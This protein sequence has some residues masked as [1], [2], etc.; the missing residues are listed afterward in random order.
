VTCSISS[1]TELRRTGTSEPFDGKV[2][3]CND[4]YGWYEFFYTHCLMYVVREEVYNNELVERMMTSRKVEVEVTCDNT[5]KPFLYIPHPTSS[6]IC[7]AGCR[8]GNMSF[9]GW[10]SHH[11]NR[12]KAE[13]NGRRR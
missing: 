9:V 3:H 4:Q 11:V 13:E 8:A 12:L 6:G 10:P 1:I 5:A 2:D 7:L